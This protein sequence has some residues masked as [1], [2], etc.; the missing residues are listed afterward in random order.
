MRVRA[1]RCYGRRVR[2]STEPP[3]PASPPQSAFRALHAC[4]ARPTLA[5]SA[6]LT[7]LTLGACGRAAPPDP[8]PSRA[9]ASSPS[10]S[11]LLAQPSR[12]DEPPAPSAS[13]SPTPTASTAASAA[14]PP[15]EFAKDAP[16]PKLR[17][18]AIGLHIGG[19]P[20]DDATK[21]PIHASVAPH[22]ETMKRCWPWVDAK[23]LRR[24]GD[25]GVDLLIEAEGGRAKVE[26]PR[27]V[28]GEAFHRCMVGVFAAI[29]FKRPKTGKTLASYSIHFAP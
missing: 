24:A 26:N 20:N 9:W 11:A 17:V 7:L 10:A 4:R 22:L 21:E 18:Y 13:G 28:K 29:E 8:P 1:A 16:S 12:D 14:S 23:E 5:A 3:S 2:R 25:F 19:G 27:G 15:I 6:L